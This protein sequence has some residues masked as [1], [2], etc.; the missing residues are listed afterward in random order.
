MRKA[1]NS[2]A[3]NKRGPV[4]FH[5]VRY[6]ISDLRHL[7]E[8]DVVYLF[9]VTQLHN[10][11]A[12]LLALVSSNFPSPE[13]PLPLQVRGSVVSFMSI[14]L[15][16]G[17]LEEGWKTIKD[18]FQMVFTKYAGAMDV[19][20]VASHKELRSYFSKKN[21]IRE[22][23]DNASFHFDREQVRAAY[24]SMDDSADLTDF[25]SRSLGNTTYFS[26]EGILTA[27]VLQLIPNREDFED[28]AD[29]I[30]HVIGEVARIAHLFLDTTTAF[31][32]EFYKANLSDKL[33]A[34]RDDF[35]TV[36]DQPKLDDMPGLQF[37]HT[38][39]DDHLDLSALT[40]RHE[41]RAAKAAKRKRS[42]K[43]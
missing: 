12:A 10:D 6:K 24:Q 33:E 43:T 2:G 41:R 7:P 36:E 1:D 20:V 38:D 27:A 4:T 30:N 28:N 29:A 8:D 18:R 14:R 16:A 5:H 23:R 34:M 42:G 32:E 13:Q 37:I 3:A 15:L 35:T 19:G 25:I 9:M 26:A 39:A 22:I 40:N 17:R 21:L 31:T 11:V